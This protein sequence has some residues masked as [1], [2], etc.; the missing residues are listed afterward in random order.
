MV[1]QVQDYPVVFPLLLAGMLT[2][3]GGGSAATAPAPLNGSGPLADG[4]AIFFAEALDFG[5]EEDTPLANQL[6]VNPDIQVTFGT[7][8]DLP[9]SDNSIFTAMVNLP[10]LRILIFLVMIRLTTMC[11]L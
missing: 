5:A 7:L 6:S 1:R 3:C 8:F 9:S 4:S 11:G 2:A 10:T